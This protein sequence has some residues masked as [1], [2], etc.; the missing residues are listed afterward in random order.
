[1]FNKDNRFD[2]KLTLGELGERWLVWM[3]CKE[4]RVEAKAEQGIWINSGNAVFEYM[5]RGKPSGISTTDSDWWSQIFMDNNEPAMIMTF[6][7]DNL[8]AFLEEVVKTPYKFNARLKN[9][10]D[11]GHDGIPT[12]KLI[13]LPIDQLH[14]AYKYKCQG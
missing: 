2:I 14:K 3:G 4:A 13:I 9:G 10:G 1:M 6:K 5:S 8:K 11:L 7:T 12:S